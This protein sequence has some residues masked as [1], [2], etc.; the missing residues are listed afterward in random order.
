MKS[1]I[2]DIKSELA[3]LGKPE[4]LALCLRLA[5]YKKDNKELLGYLLFESYNENAFI[6][7]VKNEMDEEFAAINKSNLYWAKKSLRKILRNTNKNIRYSGQ[8][9]TELELL[10]YYCTKVKSSGI[11][12]QSS[13]ALLNLYKQ[14]VKKALKI[15]DTL[16]ED[17][18]YDYEAEIE[19]L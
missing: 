18:R 17:L 12:Y 19:K 16:H 4:L 3:T 7:K 14:Q 5:K 8:K 15:V 11:S 6:Q 9:T 1:S 2:S 10:I 13:T